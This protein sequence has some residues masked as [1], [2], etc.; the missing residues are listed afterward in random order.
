MRARSTCSNQR[1]DTLMQDRIARIDETSCTARPDHTNGS[2]G[3]TKPCP[4]RGQLS[5]NAVA[6]CRR[7]LH[8]Q[9]LSTALAID[10]GTCSDCGHWCRRPWHLQWASCGHAA[11][12]AL[13][14]NGPQQEFNCAAVGGVRC[15]V[16][17]E[18]SFSIQRV[19]AQSCGFSVANFCIWQQAP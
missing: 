9:P 1:P 7:R 12:L 15:V 13:G 2:V 14:G 11:G 16:A 19:E 18:S 3:D 5:S 4:R 6:G 10:G 8:R 17:P